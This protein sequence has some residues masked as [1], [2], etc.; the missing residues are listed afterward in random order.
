VPPTPP[1][2][3]THTHTHHSWHLPFYANY[4]EM[5]RRLAEGTWRRYVW[6]LGPPRYTALLVLAPLVTSVYFIVGALV[7]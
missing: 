3:L 7:A 4:F 6:R 5:C 2:R 1:P